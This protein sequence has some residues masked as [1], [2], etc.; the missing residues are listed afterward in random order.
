MGR[1]R[2]QHEETEIDNPY[3]QEYDAIPEVASM[4]DESV[5]DYMV[6]T[7]EDDLPK[8][9]PNRIFKLLDRRRGDYVSIDGQD[10]I[11]DPVTK[12][13]RRARLLRGCDSIWMDEQK[14]YTKEY[15]DKNKIS[16]LFYKGDL[17][18]PEYEVATLRF[19]EACNS[20]TSNPNRKGFRKVYFKEWNPAKMAEESM[21]KELREIDAVMKAK[22]APIAKVKPHATYLGIKFKDAY[23]LEIPDDGIRNQYILY[24]K[25][26]PEM[27]LNSFDNPV[28][29]ISYKVTTAINTGVIDLGRDLG[30]AYWRDGG[31]ITA[32]PS[33]KDPED[34]LTH[35][36]QLPNEASV[37][38]KSR[39][40]TLIK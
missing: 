20:N 22:D 6:E 21:K 24:A 3:L 35:F 19:A 23:G 38:F 11:F 36:A 27:F 18:V 14:G 13:N 7:P 25:R 31:F 10:D 37:S 8:A 5:E 15:I 29:Q 16:L 28:T 2:K 17:I 9:A 32:M 26:N 12:T 33:D 34:F 1:P 4:E 30:M 39:L 40:E